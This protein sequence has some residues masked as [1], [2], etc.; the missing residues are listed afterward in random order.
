MKIIVDEDNTYAQEAFSS[1][2]E[3]TALPAA[4]ITR[5]V[6]RD[7]EILA[8]RST[9]RVNAELLEGTAVRCVATA[10]IGMDHFD[11]AYLD[12][13]G[14]RYCNAPG[15]NADSVADYG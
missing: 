3:A 15:C 8:C 14:I 1:L 13:A 10:T 5:Q 12:R 9:I 2:G 11:T 4:R 6:L 7:C